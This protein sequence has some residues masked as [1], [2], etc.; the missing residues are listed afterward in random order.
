MVLTVHSIN[1]TIH[2]YTH[3]LCIEKEV[4]AGGRVALKFGTQKINLHE[5]G[6]EFEPKAA[7]PTCGSADIC[8]ITHLPIREA[9]SQVEEKVVEII[10]GIVPRTGANGT[11]QSFYFRDPDQNL[12]E[13]SS[14]TNAT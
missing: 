2:F 14:Y 4:F 11:I 3:I 9:Y 6:Q 7:L 5:V 1:E 13:V 12:I 10:E 8:L